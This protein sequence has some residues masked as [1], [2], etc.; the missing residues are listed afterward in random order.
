MGQK[1][2]KRQKN[3]NW[4]NDILLIPIDLYD[5]ANNVKKIC[6]RK[7]QFLVL[8]WAYTFQKIAQN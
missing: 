5:P 6:F 2:E 7:F 1:P 3:E 4:K 8:L